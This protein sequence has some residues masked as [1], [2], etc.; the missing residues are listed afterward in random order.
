MESSV[1][2]QAAAAALDLVAASRSELADR[3]VTPWWYHP[4]LG[5]L[6]ASLVAAPAAHSK[7]VWFATTIFLVNSSLALA[8]TYRRM[9]GV[10]VSGTNAGRASRWAY[11]LG[12]VF[13]LALGLSA[14]ASLKFD[15][16]PVSIA[17]AIAQIPVT[18]LVG[19][20]F[21]TVYRRQ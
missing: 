17:I 15:L 11:A 20:H 10:W 7:A 8:R 4:V 6:I 16:W 13:A 12:A 21:D 1:G 19:R 9:T 3:L 2:P 5:V 18:V 14:L